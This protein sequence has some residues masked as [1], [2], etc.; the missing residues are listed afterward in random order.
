MCNNQALGLAAIA[1][2]TYFTA[3][4]GT[5]AAV[6]AFEGMGDA[7]GG[8]LATSTAGTATVAGT[9]ATVAGTTATAGSS[10]LLTGAALAGTA[11]TA[12][13]QIQKGKAE[14][15]MAD[16]NAN[17]ATQ[18]SNEALQMGSI[19]E[20]QQRNKV[21]QVEGSQTAAMG[22]SGAVAGSG[23]FGSVL[24]QTSQFGELDALTVRNN[25]LKQA[26]GLQTQAVG[27]QLQGSY[28]RQ[29]AAIGAAGSLL[30]GSV[31]AYGVG[32]NWGKGFGKVG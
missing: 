31:N 5:E 14:G 2:V 1:A 22:A 23:S 15:E 19:A 12:Y 4:S 10:S 26:W 29:G 25:A 9:T 28:A 30:S 21:R 16:Y 20:E 8:G 32:T 11:A 24:D 13:G 7:M 17:V 6:G 18:R 27:D 3:G